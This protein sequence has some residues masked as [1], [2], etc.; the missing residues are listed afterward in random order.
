[1]IFI[2]DLIKNEALGS[3][4]KVGEGFVLYLEIDN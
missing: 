3:L 2:E 4:E 1:M